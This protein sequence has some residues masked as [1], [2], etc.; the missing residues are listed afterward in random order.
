MTP[1]ELDRQALYY[2]AD[3]LA[4]K[5]DNVFRV[6]DIKQAYIDGYK[7]S[8]KDKYDEDIKKENTKETL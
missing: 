8:R 5:A 6:Q 2:A 1:E 7:Q 3:K 4:P